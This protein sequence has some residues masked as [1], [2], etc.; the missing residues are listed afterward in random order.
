MF[1]AAREG[2]LEVGRC[3]FQSGA[4]CDK[5]DANGQTPLYYAVK[6]VKIEMA[7]FLLSEGGAD[8]NHRDN[9]NETVMNIAKRTGKKTIITL[10]MQHGAKEEGRK[11]S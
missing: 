9:K 7:E 3:L 2:H 1:Y 5:V 11:N 6:G 10:L 4:D 8:I